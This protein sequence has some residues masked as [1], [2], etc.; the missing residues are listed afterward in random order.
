MSGKSVSE[1]IQM[2]QVELTSLYPS[3]EIRQFSRLIFNQLLGYSSTDILIKGDRILD[4]EQIDF[5]DSCIRQL[6]KEVPIQYILGQTEFLGLKLNV[7]PSVLIPRPETEELVVWV[8]FR[9][10]PKER[11]TL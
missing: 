6:K 3:S 1:I 5:L 7:N 9:V 11:T 10:V 4:G 8:A 2:M